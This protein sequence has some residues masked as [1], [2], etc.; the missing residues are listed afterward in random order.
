MYSDRV[1]EA[2]GACDLKRELSGVPFSYYESG[3]IAM[4]KP[5]KTYEE[6]VLK[7]K[8]EKK[9]SVP[10]KARVIALLKKHSYFSLVSGY[11]VLFKKPTGEYREG[12]T[13]ED[14]LSLF[15]FDNKLRD[16]FFHAIL[17]VEKHI[18]SLLSYSFSE[19]YGEAQSAYLN[20]N[21]YM[22][23]GS[24]QDETYLRCCEVKRLIQVFESKVKPP[25]EQKYI[26]HQ[27]KEHK[28][29]PLWVVIKSVTLGTTSKM[30]S[31]CTQDIQAAVSKEF[32]IVSEHQLVGMLD[33]LTRV[34]NVCAHNER[35]FDFN[36]GK[37][38]A[39]QAMPLHR[40]L[41]IGKRK[42]YYK[43]GQCDLFAA[44]V[45]LKY[46]LSPEDFQFTMDAI[47]TEIDTLCS[48]TKQLQKNKILSCMGFPLNW[49]DSVSL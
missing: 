1:T 41:G 19:K 49:Y 44:V 5:F 16:I 29:I 3:F 7:L 14:L 35:L 47:K 26:E 15:E 37:K 32:P 34:R 31:L 24:T 48:K 11:K 30:Y 45:C 46:L 21:N 17:I 28:N 36:A 25:F 33:L 12:T 43:K 27:W 38:R 2:C 4:D 8:D 39:I 18:K 42:S 20:P 10:D 23:N 13:I 6:L 22:L 9:L 40:K